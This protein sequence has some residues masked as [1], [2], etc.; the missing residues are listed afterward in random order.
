MR[1]I[2]ARHDSSSVLR[3]ETNAFVSCGYSYLDSRRI[4]PMGFSNVVSKIKHAAETAFWL[5]LQIVLAVLSLLPLVPVVLVI[6]GIVK[7]IG[8]RTLP[9]KIFSTITGSLISGPELPFWAISG[10]RVALILGLGFLS[11]WILIRLLPLSEKLETPSWIVAVAAL[12]L[13]PIFF[14]LIALAILGSLL[15][16][17]A[18]ATSVGT[19]PIALSGLWTRL[20]G[21]ASSPTNCTILT[22]ASILAGVFLYRM[23]TRFRMAYSLAEMMVGAGAC[24][25]AFANAKSDRIAGPLALI[26]G[27]YI[28]VRGCDNAV[29]GWRRRKA[30]RASAKIETAQDGGAKEASKDIEKNNFRIVKLLEQWPADKPPIDESTGFAV[31]FVSEA[32][33]EKKMIAYI[34]GYNNTMREWHATKKDFPGPIEAGS[35]L[36]AV[37][38]ANL[39]LPAGEKA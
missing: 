37:I 36:P 12:F 13:S 20:S 38:A 33:L 21:F 14:L 31:H 35:E 23:R 29:E 27:I 7:L 19:W 18:T 22:L 6:Y 4:L 34:E 16:V 9:A 11:R 3:L 8:N 2:F 25:V 39:K 17:G 26:G 10:Y 24:W 1:E 15:S 32:A 5:V 28:I 30:S